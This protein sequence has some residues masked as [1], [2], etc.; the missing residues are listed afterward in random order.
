M[1]RFGWIVWAFAVPNLLLSAWFVYD[2]GYWM[3]T[4]T[5]VIPLKGWMCWHDLA[6][7]RRV[8]FDL[9]MLLALWGSI[10]W[11]TRVER[12]RTSFFIMGGAF[13]V[14]TIAALALALAGQ[15]YATGAIPQELVPLDHKFGLEHR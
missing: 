15:C 1:Q 6:P 5:V 7:Q 9:L 12:L 4:S 13:F 14:P 2:F 11:G 3:T 10:A 8:V